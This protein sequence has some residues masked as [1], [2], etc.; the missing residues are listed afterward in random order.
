ML[1]VSLSTAVFTIVSCWIVLDKIEV[2][3]EISL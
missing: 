1:S 2:K 3:E